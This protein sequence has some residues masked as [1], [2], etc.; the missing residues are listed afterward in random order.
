MKKRKPKRG[1]IFYFVTSYMGNSSAKKMQV[2]MNLSRSRVP[3][4]G[5]MHNPP[6]RKGSMPHSYR[7]MTAL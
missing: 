1:F 2:H 5:K 6:L 4:N 3:K 7:A